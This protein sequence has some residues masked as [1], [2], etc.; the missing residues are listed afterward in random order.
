MTLL[1][2]FSRGI[3][4]VTTLLGRLCWWVTLGMILVG[5]LNVVTR[6]VGRTFGLSLGGTQYIVLQT[7][8]FDFVFLM[9]AAYVLRRDGHVRVDIIFSTLS[10]RAKAVIDVLGTLLFLIPFCVLGI[11]FSRGYIATSWRQGEVNLAGGGIP[12]YPVKTLIIVAFALLI[13]QGVSELIKN[14]AF[15]SG[16]RNTG[17]VHEQPSGTG[18][19]I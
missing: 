17:S 5:L 8:A 10:A 9:A 18:E 19:G 7:Y 1:L 6:Y 16:R 12:V 14:L 3:D 15:L 4:A 2:A 13:A 11:H